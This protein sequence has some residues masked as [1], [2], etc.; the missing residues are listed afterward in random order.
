MYNPICFFPRS[1]HATLRERHAS[2]TGREREGRRDDPA[3]SGGGGSGGGRSPV[4]PFTPAP[5]RASG[6]GREREGRR[7]SLP[8]LASLHDPSGGEGSGGEG[9][10]T[11]RKKGAGFCESRPARATDPAR[12]PHS[13]PDPTQQSSAPFFSR[14]REW[15]RASHVFFP[16]RLPF[17]VSPQVFSRDGR[18]EREGKRERCPL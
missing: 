2:G 9:S 7:D 1:R 5:R 17:T 13:L 12:P 10:G 16:T 3:G 15:K 18:R 4:F 8:A 14:E 6:T 11:G